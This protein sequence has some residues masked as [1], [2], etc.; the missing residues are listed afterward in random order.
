MNY[1]TTTELRTRSSELIEA[2]KKG[3]SVSL[4]HRSRIVGEFRPKRQAQPMTKKDIAQLRQLAEELNLPK[5]S[6]KE[7]ERRYRKHLMQKYGKGLS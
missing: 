5:L 4:V 1:I 6:Y 7:R 3:T 2:L